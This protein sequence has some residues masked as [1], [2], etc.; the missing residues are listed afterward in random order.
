MAND[1]ACSGNLLGDA[2]D[3]VNALVRVLGLPGECKS[4]FKSP[5]PR[6]AIWRT[7]AAVPSISMPDIES[8]LT[9]LKECGWSNRLGR[10][11]PGAR[12]GVL[13]DW[14]MSRV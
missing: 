2:V 11:V 14:A 7:V 8:P 5:P 9:H 1:V 13:E 10:F 12:M 4:L 6:S 3:A